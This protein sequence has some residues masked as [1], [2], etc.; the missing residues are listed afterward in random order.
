MLYEM[1]CNASLM[2]DRT[3][4][5]FG[6]SEQNNKRWLYLLHLVYKLHL[7]LIM[8]STENKNIKHRGFI[9][10]ITECRPV[11]TSGHLYLS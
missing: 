9:V 10:Q 6:S 5:L 8:M 2:E 4:N 11:T 7:E 1:K 3:H